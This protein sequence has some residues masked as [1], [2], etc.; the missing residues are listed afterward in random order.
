MNDALARGHVPADLAHA[1]A[2]GIAGDT[3]REMLGAFPDRI[4]VAKL[5]ALAIREARE[6]KAEIVASFGDLSIVSASGEDLER[7]G[8][9]GLL[10]GV[11]REIAGAGAH[12]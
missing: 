10:R 12:G 6:A 3:F 9:A 7:L 1:G 8:G 11:A 2:I 4:P 5:V